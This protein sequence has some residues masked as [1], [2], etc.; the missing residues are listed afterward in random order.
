M[1]DLTLRYF[2][3]ICVGLWALWFFFR[4]TRLGP[5]QPY[6]LNQPRF[7]HEGDIVG[8]ILALVLLYV[9]FG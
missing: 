1:H 3:E 5:R 7:F 9:V 2:L 8:V 4:A 6:S